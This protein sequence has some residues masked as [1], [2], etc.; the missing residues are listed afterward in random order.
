MKL[1]PFDQQ[2][3]A[4]KSDAQEFMKQFYGVSLGPN[5]ARKQKT[6]IQR[7]L[8]HKKRMEEPEDQPTIDKLYSHEDGSQTRVMLLRISEK[9]RKD[10]EKLMDLMGYDPAKWECLTNE[11]TLNDWGVTMKLRKDGYDEPSYHTN[12]QYKVKLRVKPRQDLISS[13]SIKSIFKDLVVPVIEAYKYE[14]GEMMFEL[15]MMDVHLMKRS[16]P[17]ETGEVYDLGTAI[18]L[19]KATVKDIYAKLMSIQGLTFEKIV[20]PFG[21]DFFQYDNIDRKTTAGTPVENDGPY[22][23]MY[24][25]GIDLMLWHVELFRPLAPIYILWIPGNHD[26]TLSYFA[27]SGLARI[28]EDVAGVEVDIAPTSR[29]YVRFGKNL[30]GFSHGKEEGKRIQTLMQQEAAEDWGKT[31][32][33]E[34]HLGDLHHEAAEEIGGIIHR[35]ISSITAAD[36][37]HAKKGFR[38]TRK[39]NGYVWDKERGLVFTISS[40]VVSGET[41]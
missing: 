22:Y 32:F 21:Q 30:I 16:E 9:E 6:G 40:N 38:A 13:E 28:Y 17:E 4:H 1:D 31:T 25:A 19:Y 10:P 39:A 14:P 7:H 2:V 24:E 41:I 27:V 29:K 36:G 12:H 34:W 15:P 35:R 20:I 18:R 11:T 3:L 8:R 5:N 37:W 33:R 26:W 23:K